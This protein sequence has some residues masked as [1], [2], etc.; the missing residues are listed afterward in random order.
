MNL[1]VPPRIVYTVS[2]ISRNIRLLIERQFPDVWIEGEVSNLRRS[3]A[4]HLYFTLKDDHSQIPAVCFRSQARY[5]RFRPRDGECFRARGRIGTYEARGEYQ[6][7]VDVLEPAGRGALQAAFDRLKEKLEREGLFDAS[8]KKPLPRFPSRIGIVTSPGSAALYDILSVLER[9]NSAIDVWIYPT[10]VQGAAAAASLRAGVDYLSTA[11][12]DVVILA[13]GGGSVE[14]LWPFSDE[15]VARAVFNCRKPVISAVGHETDFVISDFVADVRAPTPSA[16]AEMVVRSKQ[17]LLDRLE[18]AEARL[19]QSMR[20]RLAQLGRFL[21]VR[22]GGRGFAIAEQRI[23]QMAQRVDDCS[24]RLVHFARSGA[25]LGSIAHRLDRAEGAARTGVAR[26]A[27]A[28]R[29]R[30]RTLSETLDALSPLGV[31]DRGYAVCRKQDGTIV[32]SGRQVG[33]DEPLEVLLHEGSLDV[34]VRSVR[35]ERPGAR[36]PHE[37]AR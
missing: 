1:P 28:A 22:A 36:G 37:D 26:Q 19:A 24:F 32:T 25:L 12:V 21:S 29:E 5:L 10:E 17:E 6:I 16:A 33:V 20:F 34:R 23:R 35:H 14:D 4:G 7:L 8:H 11:D 3:A 30:F 15:A 31:L 2:E 13:R 27:A 9:R 18:A